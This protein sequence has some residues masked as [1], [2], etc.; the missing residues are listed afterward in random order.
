[1]LTPL[2]F[3]R[4]RKN[5]VLIVKLLSQSILFLKGLVSPDSD[6]NIFP[7]LSLIRVDRIKVLVV[8]F[9]SLMHQLIK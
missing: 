7:Y 5:L 2:M 1:M 8:L 3:L 4:Q 6:N 9:Y